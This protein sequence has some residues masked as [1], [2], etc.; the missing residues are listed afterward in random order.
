MD[1]KY[2]DLAETPV[3]EAATE[4]VIKLLADGISV[5]DI[6]FALSY[7]ATDLSLQLAPSA[8]HAIAV[9]ADA[10]QKSAVS[11]ACAISQSESTSDVE[12]SG[13]SVNP[14]DTELFGRTVH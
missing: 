9:V 10:I 3:F 8:A 13:D 14:I 1:K 5:P 4:L 12:T 2:N 11:H 6:S 7:V